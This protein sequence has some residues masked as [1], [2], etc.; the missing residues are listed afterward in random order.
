MKKLKEIKNKHYCDYKIPSET[1]LL[2]QKNANNLNSFKHAEYAK[3]TKLNQPKPALL[4]GL[5][6]KDKDEAVC[7]ELKSQIPSLLYLFYKE[8]IFTEKFIEGKMINDI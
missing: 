6:S 8:E 2:K 7:N 4:F 5:F 1:E 3:K